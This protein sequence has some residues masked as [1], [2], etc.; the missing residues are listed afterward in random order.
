[1]SLQ[2]SISDLQKTLEKLYLQLEQRFN[3]NQIIRNL[4]TTMAHDI[5]QQK[6]SMSL[7]PNS[8]WN[9]LKDGKEGFPES[10]SAILR[11][12]IDNKVDSSLQ[13]CF[14]HAL[15]FEEPIVSKVYVPVIRKLRE[16]WT[17]QA[18]DFYIMV[19]SHLAR[20]A[21]VTQ[22]FAGDPETIRR[23]SLLLQ[24]FEKEVQEPKVVALKPAASK[25][26]SK[27]PD[28][29]QK[30]KP[31]PKLKKKALPKLAKS[32]SKR[33]KSHRPATKP[34]VKKISLPR[35]RARR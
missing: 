8:F 13:S 29:S 28:R 15:F 4:W 24:N 26:S 35:R 3:E 9:K 34:L 18:L 17:N 25:A 31:A 11:Q 23:S 6:H 2:G 1:M 7:I 32:L 22:A 21:R 20:I 5:V 12:N 14:D 16:D 19:K 27:K 30:T 33:G 10:V